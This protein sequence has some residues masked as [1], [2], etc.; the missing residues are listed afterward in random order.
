MVGAA[1]KAKRNQVVLSTKSHSA[2]RTEALQD[3]DTSL[4]ELGTDH[5]D[6]WYLHGKSRPEEI[7]DDLIDA[8]QTAKKAGKIRFAGCSNLSADQLEEALGVSERRRLLAFVTCQDRYN[9]LE[10]GI[11]KDLV[12]AMRQG[13]LGLLPF[14][15]LA[16]GLLTGKYRPDA[17]PPQG[18]RLAGSAR[19]QGVLNERNWRI[20]Q[21]LR[22]FAE[23][24][25]HTLLELAMSWL[26]CRPFVAS[27]IAGATRP[28]QIE[29]NIAAVR[30]ELAP[31]DLTMIDRITL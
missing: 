18:T 4:K 13:D 22:A 20:V 19:H 5:V 17:P 16:S 26:A 21:A 30:W 24:R 9:L 29:Q 3:L 12:P 8:Q 14:F 15:P 6:I 23:Q 10:R 31:A 1:L 2:T 27:I 25:G 28:E 11:E 7:T